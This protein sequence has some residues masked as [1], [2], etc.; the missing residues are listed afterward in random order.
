MYR[1]LLN[2]AQLLSVCIVTVLFSACGGQAKTDN[3]DSLKKDSAT[4]VIPTTGPTGK[5]IG[6]WHDEAIKSE[7]GESIAYELVEGSDKIYLQAITF[8]GTK[9]KLNDTPPISSSATEVT[10]DGDKCTSVERPNET[11]VIAKDGDLMIYDGTELIT[12][13][14][15][16]L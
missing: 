14:K 16:L 1:N 6:A 5:L 11:Y 12:K 10:K 4:T 15:K 13:C 3:K 9:L 2:T 7:K 8:V